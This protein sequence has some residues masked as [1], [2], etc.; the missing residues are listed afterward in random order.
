MRCTKKEVNI[1]YKLAQEIDS[2]D[3]EKDGCHWGHIFEI[4]EKTYL[5]GKKEGLKKGQL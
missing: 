2:Y 4:V 5:K 3:E 1:C